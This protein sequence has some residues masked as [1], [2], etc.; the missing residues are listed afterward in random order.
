MQKAHLLL[1]VPLL[2]F[3][4]CII[5]AESNRITGSGL[6]ETR[7]VDVSN[8]TGVSMSIPGDL[9]L[10]QGSEESLRISAQADL[11]PFINIFVRDGRLRIETNDDVSLDPTQP[12]TITIGVQNLDLLQFA[13]TG[14]VRMD[15]LNTID[16]N[17]DLTGSGE[18]QFAAFSAETLDLSLTGSGNLDFSGTVIAQN[19]AITGSGDLEARNL[20]SQDADVS[21][22]GS[23]SAVINVT[24][25][26]TANIS[27]SGNIRYRGTPT[28]EAAVTGSGSVEPLGE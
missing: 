28:V 3:S 2:V 22:S 7:T 4:S 15:T 9:T 8:F 17:L 6:L 26:L 25:A 24:E 5:G 10:I 20:E 18:M 16:F 12:I 1:I 13:G 11:Y 23:G 27:G 21:I 19:I 14:T